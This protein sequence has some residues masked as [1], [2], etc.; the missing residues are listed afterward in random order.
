MDAILVNDSV[1]QGRGSPVV[2]WPLPRIPPPEA[3]AVVPLSTVALGADDVLGNSPDIARIDF[4]AFCRRPIARIL[5]LKLDHYGDFI[6]GLPAL[7]A[8]REAFPR[9]EIRLVC[10][11]WNETSARASGLVDEVR[12]FNF[13]PERPTHDATV[14]P[15]P[16]GPFDAAV[17][18][19]WDIAID[20]RVDE[21]TRHLLSRIDALI[22]CG[23][24]SAAQFPMLDIALPHEHAMRAVVNGTDHRVIFF[25][26][27]RFNSTL[28]HKGPLRQFGP[29]AAGEIIHGPFTELPTGRLRVELG[30]TLRG[31][32]PGVLPASIV[33]ELVRDGGQPVARQVFG[34]RA[35][36]QLRNGPIAFE[37]DNPVQGSR[38][39]FRVAVQ[40]RPAGGTFQFTGATVCQLAVAP[41]ARYLPSE[42]HVGEKLSLL[43]SLVRDRTHDLYQAE[44][45]RPRRDQSS[46]LRIAVAPFSNSRIRNWPA[47]HYAALISLLLERMDCEVLLLG[48]QV[49]RDDAKAITRVVHS[50][51]LRDMVGRTT[52]S[53]LQ[54]TLRDSD[55]VICN[56]SGTAHQAA[57]LG[58]RVLA[59][60]SGSHQPREWGPRGLRSMAIMRAVPC[61]PCGFES[62]AQCTHGHACMREI[63]PEYVMSSGEGGAGGR[64]RVATGEH[65]SFG[66][67]YARTRASVTA[68]SWPATA[69]HQ[70][71]LRDLCCKGWRPSPFT[72][73][74]CPSRCAG[75]Q[76][77]RSMR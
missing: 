57:A 28:P 34:R 38:F 71:L 60:Y 29:L 26:P 72:M 31:H 32:I 16:L 21:D 67:A 9:A 7:R 20:L 17:E 48:T 14:E 8:L 18:G 11:H 62:L 74:L 33:C 36:L 35:A 77:N 12:C 52:W 41:S 54:D 25:P 10:G 13:F 40:G 6:I 46:A 50:P 43:V 59:I 1:F 69:G 23:V 2:N 56:N 53:E 45:D 76:P 47:G 55:L 37:F 58:T 63:S 24:G 15:V 44:P 51:R 19:L 42:L 66:A 73:G 64:N 75:R 49:Q 22:R 30:L 5:A 4:G 70:Q 27:D 68:A 61:S 39:S 3:E 65:K